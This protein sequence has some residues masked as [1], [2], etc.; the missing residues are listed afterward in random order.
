MSYH[1]Q[2]AAKRIKEGT[3]LGPLITLVVLVVIFQAINPRFLAHDNVTTILRS[4]PYTGILAI[5]LTFCLVGGMID[6]SM[7]AI[8]GFA[9]V[10][11][12][13]ISKNYNLGIISVIIALALSSLLGF[14]NGKIT[15]KYKIS[16]IIVTIGSMYIIRG[17]ANVISD[18]Y[19]IYPIGG[20][21]ESFGNASPLGVSWAFFIMVGLGLIGE[22]V[23][24]NTVWGLCVK[25]TGSDRESAWCNEVDVDRITIQTFIILAVMAALAGILLSFRINSGLSSIGLGW[26]LNAI[27]ACTIGGVS[28]FGYDGT[29]INA[30]IGLLIVQVLSNGLV[31]IGIPAH[32]QPVA[33][34]IVMIIS[35]VLDMKRKQRLEM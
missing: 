12:A 30:F 4:L 27:A 22:V 1:R 33:V 31:V 34:G 16:S 10:V 24:Q 15:T 9:S 19:V 2:I 6:I 29:I 11:M 21:I 25:A 28:L 26:E 3:W 14:I 32:L 18:G 7:G 23:L 5:G 35:V 8:S 13:Y 17:L 20:W